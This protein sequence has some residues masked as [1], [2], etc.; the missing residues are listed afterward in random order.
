VGL[1]VNIIA[2]LVRDEIPAVGIVLFVVVL[3]VGHIFNFLV[4]MLAAF[5]HPARLIF[6][7]FFNRFYESG[8]VE[9]TPL[10]LSTKSMIV[11]PDG[12]E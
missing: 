10:S 12:E 4:S 6:L 1:A 3:V 9:F 2:K 7:E 11:E 5:V 8:G